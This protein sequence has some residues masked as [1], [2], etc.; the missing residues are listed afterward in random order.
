LLE[1]TW[2]IGCKQ[3]ARVSSARAEGYAGVVPFVGPAGLGR[4]D[5]FDK[6]WAACE[7]DEGC[8]VLGGLLAA[9]GDALEALELSNRLLDPGAA[10]VEDLWEEAGPVLDV[11]AVWDGGADA[12]LSGGLPVCF[13]VVA[14]VGECGPRP[15]VGADVEERLELVAVAG[16]AAGQVE[17]E[18]IAPEVCLEVDLGRESATRAAEGLAVLP[19]PRTPN[20]LPS[21]PSE[22]SASL[23]ADLL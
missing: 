12:S 16:L 23:K 3:G 20:P 22:W 8:V 14:F 4:V 19:P 5:G 6:D 13:G 17:V 18:R 21:S 11:R 9:Q 7:G 10:F 1:G 2:L 15:N